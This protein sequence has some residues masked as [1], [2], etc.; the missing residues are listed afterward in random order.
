MKVTA[1]CFALLVVALA[2]SAQTVTAPNARLTAR[3]ISRT[4]DR[5]VVAK[6]D[7]TLTIGTT[8]ITANEAVIEHG[9]PG[10]ASDIS[11]RGA[12][13]VKAILQ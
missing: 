8:V 4:S 13:R 10:K 9:G 6:G 1:A 7:V 11:L 12:V 2:A 5:R 3:E